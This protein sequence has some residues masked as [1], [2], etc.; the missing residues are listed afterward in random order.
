[1]SQVRFANPADIPALMDLGRQIHAQSRYAWMQFNAIR[2]WT[3]LEAAIT[4]KQHCIIVATDTGIENDAS[5]AKLTGVLWANAFG[6][7][8]SSERV[9]QIDYLYVT[10]KRRGTP[11]TMKMMAGLRRWAHNREVAE[12]VL[13]NAFGVDEVYSAKLLSKLGLKPVGGVHSM[14]V[15]RQ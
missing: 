9:A 10:P 6:L 12:I 14:W 1:M 8:F 7:P 5:A 2:L 11:T 3:S 15:D 13:K 4:N